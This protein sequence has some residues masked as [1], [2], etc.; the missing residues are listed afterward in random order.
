MY[1]ML[2]VLVFFCFQFCF[3]FRLNS[4]VQG[5]KV[6]WHDQMH[7]FIVEFG[8][9]RVGAHGCGSSGQ[10]GINSLSQIL[11]AL[12]HWT[13]HKPEAAQSHNSSPALTPKGLF[14]LHCT[15]FWPVYLCM[16]SVWSLMCV[17]QLVT[18]CSLIL[19]L[20]LASPSRSHGSSAG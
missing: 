12:A 1:W 2:F 20:S 17:A 4:N 5:D 11:M 8:G 7:Q 9:W 14:C 6:D 16:F 15:F 19:S 18:Q 3:P 13:F 10:K